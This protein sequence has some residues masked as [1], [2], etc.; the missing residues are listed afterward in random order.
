MGTQSSGKTLI[1]GQDL[2]VSRYMGNKSFEKNWCSGPNSC[3]FEQ[4][5]TEDLTTRACWTNLGAGRQILVGAARLPHVGQPYRPETLRN[6]HVAHS[7]GRL[8]YPGFTVL[9]PPGAR[10]K[11]IFALACAA[12]VIHGEHTSPT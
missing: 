1:L 5:F 10:K 7:Q 6:L 9:T 12:C 11:N 8:T 4:M 2:S 3:P